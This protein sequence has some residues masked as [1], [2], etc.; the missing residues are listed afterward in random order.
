MVRRDGA[1]G[2][3][4]SGAPAGAAPGGDARR[5]RPRRPRP[6]GN[7]DNEVVASEGL[8][9]RRGRSAPPGSAG[10]GSEFTDAYARLPPDLREVIIDDMDEKVRAGS[11]LL[12]TN[13]LDA[14]D[15]FIAEIF[16]ET[17]KVREREAVF[18]W[19]GDAPEQQQRRRV[20]RATGGAGLY[21]DGL[22]PAPRPLQQLLLSAQPRLSRASGLALDVG[23]QAH[24]AL[25]S[26]PYFTARQVHAL[27]ARA[28]D[29]VQT[30]L[31]RMAGT[32]KASLLLD[33]VIVNPAF[34]RGLQRDEQLQRANADEW[35]GDA[36][37]APAAV[38]APVQVQTGSGDED[39]DFA[40][41]DAVYAGSAAAAA[42]SAAASASSEASA[43]ASG[44]GGRFKLV[45]KQ[46]D[47]E[48]EAAPKKAAPVPVKGKAPPKAAA[49]PAAKPAAAAPAAAAA[50]AAPKKK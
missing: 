26:S 29:L 45:A 7:D 18:F 42:A 48:E 28:A 46:W 12:D 8:S 20:R 37:G 17:A 24:A 11:H 6:A 41:E 4:P 40:D 43:A 19:E 21:A 38:Q 10:A 13:E 16:N 39:E 14:A 35:Y 36:E 32:S 2:P 49:K 9:R 25:A 23:M 15:S 22:A 34:R 3:A 44:L 30:V 27:S 1:Q 50:A 31:P 5:S 33:D 47:E